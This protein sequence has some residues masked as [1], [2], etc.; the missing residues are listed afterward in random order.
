[1]MPT[2]G[3]ATLFA[4][5]A[6][7]ILAL[8]A[9]KS[10]GNGGDGGNIAVS[11]DAPQ[12]VKTGEVQGYPLGS[13]I[14]GR[15]VSPPE[16]T[17]ADAL[18]LARV[19][20]LTQ[21]SEQIQTRV[22]SELNSIQR[23]VAHNEKVESFADVVIRSR[24]ETSDLLAG[25]N[26]VAEW[27]DA[28]S[29]TGYVLMAMNRLA[30]SERLCNQASDK[31]AEAAGQVDASKKAQ[32]RGD[33]GAGLKSLI[34]ARRAMAV[35]LSNHAKALAVGTTDELKKR[36]TGM[37]LGSF[38]NDVVQEYDTLAGTVRL[39]PVSGNEQVASL[40]G[41]LKKPVTVRVAGRNG[42][43]LAGF[44]VSVRPG[45]GAEDKVTV[46]PRADG[47]DGE[48]LFSF[49]LKELVATGAHSNTVTVALDYAAIEPRTDLLPL[50]CTITYL[51]PTKETTR[52]A[53]VIHETICGKENANSHTASFIKSA[54]T[55]LGFQVIRPDI[56][57]QPKSFVDQ[58]P[59][60][61]ARALADQCEYVIVGTAESSLSSEDR[62]F[63]CFKTRLVLDALELDSA[64]T[65]HFEIPMEQATKGF[66]K[67]DAEAARESLKNAALVMVGGSKPGEEGLLG[68][69]FVARFESDAEWEE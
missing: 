15:G 48:G 68:K 30:L 19:D 21:I 32:E 14:R 37:D 57:Q 22:Q 2:L 28:N 58:P 44:P 16:H 24:V 12:W 26:K 64:K 38:W 13:F 63:I 42:K 9:C 66:G 10:T 62:G 49:T 20:G 27:Y 29:G 11:P 52:I 47:T 8:P 5:A 51:M 61:L 6:A 18:A 67:S 43:P 4:L 35:A 25:A 56:G 36:F 33:P 34:R 7:V 39:E 53:V 65:I 55:D 31:K 3:N 50:S 46:I 40:S 41:A 1:M 17:E 59:K 45:E 60:A 23:E 54:L 69:K